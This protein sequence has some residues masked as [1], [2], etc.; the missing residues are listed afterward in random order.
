[1]ISVLRLGHRRERDHRITTHIGLVARA[2]GAQKLVLSGQR[3]QKVL[4]S[5]G[6]VAREWGGDF[7]AS[8]E[9]DWRKII[10]EF[11]G[12]KIHLTMY[13]LPV[14]KKLV[15]LKKKVDK[16]VI[17]GGAKVPPEV[18]QLADLNV[19]VTNQPHSEVAAL[20]LILD[21]VFSGK[22]LDKKFGGKIE[23]IPTARGKKTV[24]NV[25]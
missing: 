4:E 24:E 18:Y 9:K 6:K 11:E 15:D 1:M 16:L 17:V 2:F 7:E 23:I 20:A 3:D 21:R 14:Q 8:Y 12:Q 22:E 5:L 19:S 10:R 25:F 13:G